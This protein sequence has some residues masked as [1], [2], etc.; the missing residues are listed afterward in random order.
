M[1]RKGTF[2][3][4]KVH[5]F[6]PSKEEGNYWIDATFDEGKFKTKTEL[7]VLD[8]DTRK[9]IMSHSFTSLKYEL[10]LPKR[11]ADR[12][13]LRDLFKGQAKLR[14]KVKNAGYEIVI[15]FLVKNYPKE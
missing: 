2:R 11:W 13:Y 12:L 10:V 14:K 6:R 4:L 5:R 8:L 9:E 3:Y 1:H 15:D 7:A